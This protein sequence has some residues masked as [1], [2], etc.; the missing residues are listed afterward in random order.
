MCGGGTVFEP[1]VEYVKPG[2][3]IIVFLAFP[4]FPEENADR[5]VRVR[6]SSVMIQAQKLE[7]LVLEGLGP[8]PLNSSR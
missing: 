6:S 8:L 1:I 2:E 5:S 4:T 7:L 3:S